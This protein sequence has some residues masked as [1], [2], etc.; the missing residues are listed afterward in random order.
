MIENIRIANVATYGTT[1]EVL[2]ELS[3]FNFI[4]GTNGSGK[5]TISRIISDAASYPDCHVQWKGNTSLQAMVYNHDFI[6]RNFTQTRELKGIFTLGESQIETIEQIAA[7][8]KEIDEIT[9][10]N[11]SLQETLEGKD[12]NG[13]KKAELAT[14]ELEFKSRVWELKKKYEGDFAAAF[15]GLRNNTEKFRDRF[16]QEYS[17]NK[18]SLFSLEELKKKAQSIFGSNPIQESFVPVPEGAFL[19]DVESSKIL[20]KPIIG[21]T[22]VDIAAMIQKLGNSDWVKT[23]KEYYEVN[24]GICPFCQQPTPASFA[25]SLTEYFDETFLRDTK[26]LDE[27]CQNYEIEYTKIANILESINI[28]PSRFLE[29]ER[30]AT[31]VEL[32]NSK[33]LVNRQKLKEKKTEPSRILGLE[34]LQ[35]FFDSVVDLIEAAN[36]KIAEH[37]TLVVNLVAEKKLLTSQV[38][39]LILEEAKSDLSSYLAKTN[40]LKKAIS[41][42]DAQILKNNAEKKTTEE[43]VRNLEKNTTSIK[44]TIVGI[45]LLLEQFGFNSFTL[46]KAPNSNSYQLLR[47]DGSEA[48]ATLSEGEKSFVCFL[49]FYY[50]LKGSDSESG[51][52]ADRIV[53]FD[54][55][56]SSLDSDILFIVSSLIKGLFDEVRNK[57][58]HIKQIFVF[59]HNVYF[60]KEITF[61]S[62]RRNNQ[63]MKEETF[64]IVR[65]T[66][67]GT[68]VLKCTENTIKT[69]YD[70]L[71]A[72][73]RCE[74][75]SPLT[76]QNTLRRIFENYFKILGGIDTDDICNMFSGPEKLICNSLFSWVN[77]GS[78]FAQDDLY[79][80][81]DSSQVDMYLTVFR[82][83]FEKSNHCA[84]Y[85]MMMGDAYI[86]QDSAAI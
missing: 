53:V 18:A 38:W 77:D 15:E 60:H 6:E 1:P 23:G 80:S 42:L 30:F 26:E 43:V 41:G 85:R 9:K 29:I 64:W 35:E 56:V 14:I 74:H 3:Q 46:R 75:K 24:D 78:H 62:K 37:N 2:D 81:I 11:N 40:G 68:K 5:T 32:L 52:T 44:P 61:N 86:E 50:L 28:V 31:A 20:A 48:K 73:V 83:I 10:K 70:L 58:G 67:Q 79:V 59:T 19:I 69:S 33:W 12:R 34:P 22:D 51:T 84:H 54:D 7:H 63:A 47:P 16:I 76:I 25:Q 82:M 21:K 49:Y 27:L 36:K 8:K 13:G 65:K 71:W 55:P 72:E 4:Y 39:R 45:N 57:I 66:D 17:N